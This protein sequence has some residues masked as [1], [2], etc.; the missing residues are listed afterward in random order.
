[1]GLQPTSCEI[2]TWDEVGHWTDWDTQMPWIDF[3]KFILRERAWKQGRGRE[4]GRKR[5]PSRLHAVSAEP[6]VGLDP[7]NCEIMTWAEIKSQTPNKL[8]HPGTLGHKFLNASSH[9]FFLIHHGG[10]QTT[11]RPS[12]VHGVP[13]WVASL[14]AVQ[15]QGQGIVNSC[16]LLSAHW[17]LCP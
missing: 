5:I 17:A 7:M 2:M 9:F 11:H 14:Q 4:R 8:S 1:M 16:V 3:L 12:T 6:N 13:L 15:E 10:S